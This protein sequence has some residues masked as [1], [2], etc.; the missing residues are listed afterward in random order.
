LLRWL[1]AG[2]VT[3]P[4]QYDGGGVKVRLWTARDVA[5]VQRY[6]KANYRKGRGR[7]KKA[8]I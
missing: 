5:R 4:K 1:W 6:K 2:K 7:K 3:E 8:V